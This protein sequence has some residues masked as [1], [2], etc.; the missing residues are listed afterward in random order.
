ML[1]PI[2]W[3]WFSD[4]F[5]REHSPFSSFLLSSF[6]RGTLLGKLSYQEASPDVTPWEE[7]SVLELPCPH[8][9][10]ELCNWGPLGWVPVMGI[11]FLVSFFV[12]K[13]MAG[14]GCQLMSNIRSPFFFPVN[15]T[16]DF[17]WG[18]WPG[19]IELRLC[20]IAS[21]AARCCRVTEFWPMA[22]NESMTC[23]L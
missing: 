8:I 16:T 6:F 13:R 4:P 10:G 19:L 14:R 12:G 9:P 21:L 18:K 11:C 17:Q 2:V 1:L 20:F 7:R 22:D 15:R 3:K 23:C 5:L